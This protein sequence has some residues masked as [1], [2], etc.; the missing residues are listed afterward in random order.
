MNNIKFN[1][2]INKN[3]DSSSINQKLNVPQNQKFQL[4][5][6]NSITQETSSQLLT[7]L[8]FLLSYPNTLG[9]NCLDA[10]HR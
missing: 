1:N 7:R 3:F 6:A 2:G 4:P 8:L 9:Y 10:L 5:A